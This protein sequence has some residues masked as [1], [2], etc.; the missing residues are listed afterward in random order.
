[1]TII[2]NA[3]LLF[4]S[5]ECCAAIWD[6]AELLGVPRHA[7]GLHASP[8]GWWTGDVQLLQDG[9]CVLDGRNLQSIQGATIGSEWLGQRLNFDISTVAATCIL[10]VEKE[11]IYKRLSEDRFFERYPCVIV[12]GRGF[13]DLATR[14][15][16]HHLHRVLRLPVYGVCD[17]NPFGVM[18]LHNY[19]ESRRSSNV[20]V[21]MKWIGLRPCQIEQLEREGRALPRQVFQELT[22]VDEQ[23]LEVHLL[24]GAHGWIATAEDPDRRI[25]ELRQM[26]QFK[27]ELE[28][29]NWLGMDFFSDWLARILE[30]PEH[31][32]GG[33]GGDWMEII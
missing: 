30:Y 10:V 7:L 1:M 19:Q 22:E 27:V 18:V 24:S 29:L 25:K 15:C 32:Q 21:P 2:C 9:I 20:G 26:R 5:K 8:R 14:A 28:A 16:V 31:D 17:S 33:E 4:S 13:P 3:I 12:T 23:R 11:G 6:A